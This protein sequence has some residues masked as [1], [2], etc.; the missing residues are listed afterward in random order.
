MIVFLRV[1]GPVSYAISAYFYFK[2]FKSQNEKELRP[3]RLSFVFGLI[4][5]TVFLVMLSVEKGHLPLN[6]PFQAITTF[7]W[8]FAVLNRIVIVKERSYALGVFH[9][10]IIFILHSIAMLFIEVSA[11]TPE[12]LKNLYFEVHVIFNLLAYAAFSLSF[13]SG[14]M[15]VLLFHEIKS[16]HLGYFYERLPSLSFLEKKIHL[17]LA[18]GFVFNSFGIVLG[19]ITGKTAWGTYWS[20]DPKLI[21][22]LISWLIFGLALLGKK[23]LNWPGNRLAYFSIIG[24]SWIIFS[25]LVI[26]NYFSKLHS[27]H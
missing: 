7:I 24:Y 8:F 22:V 17:S 13:L 19:A 21:A 5:H 10:G 15:Y 18:L 11:P 2:Y 14:L 26:N 23:K 3:A 16:T 1:L 6:D 27:F 9:A 4:L 20:W 25:M 12:I